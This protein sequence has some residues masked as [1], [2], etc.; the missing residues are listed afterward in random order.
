MNTILTILYAASCLTIW[1]W[2]FYAMA[3]QNYSDLVAALFVLIILIGLIYLEFRER[4][5]R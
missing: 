4:N 5:I 1:S 3:T 2:C